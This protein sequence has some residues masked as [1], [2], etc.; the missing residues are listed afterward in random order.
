MR[1]AIRYEPLERR[2]L[3]AADVHFAIDAAQNVHPIS[4]F[5]YGVNESLAGPYSNL[6][7]TRAGGNRWTAYNWENNGSNAGSDYYFQ[8]DSYL[9]GGN[10]PGGAVMPTLNDASSHNAGAIVTIPMAG[11]VSADKNG[12][13][14]VRYNN[15]T[16]NGSGWT[17]G[18]PNPN[19]LAERFRQLIARKGSA[20][21]LTPNTLDPNVYT[22]E[23]VNWIKTNYAYGFT[24]PNR[25]IWFDLDNEPDLWSSTHA[26]VHP[27][28][29]T[30]AEMVQKTTEYA[31]AIKDVI[32]NALILG[33]VNY[34]WQ[35]YVRLQDAPDANN[36]DFQQFF[37]QQMQQ[38]SQTAGRRLLDVMD[39]HW[40]PEAQGT[41]GVRITNQD[42][43]AATVAAR[44]QAPRSLWDPAYT[45]TS[46]ITQWSTQGPIN[47]I[48]RL[49]T[50]INTYYPGTKLAISEYNY[51]GGN[52]ISGG[53]AQAD[54]LGILGREGVFGA[55]LWRLAGDESFIGGA[56]RMFRNYDGANSTFGD[57]SVR[58]TT[59]N[60]ANTSIYASYDQANRSVLTLV[61]INKTA[62]PLTAG[63]DLSHVAAGSQASVWRL[64]SANS[65]PQSAGTISIGNPASFEYAMPAYSV[66]TIRINLATPVAR[67][68]TGGGDN[69][70]WS[71]PANWSGNAVPTASD[72][73]IISV[74]SA[75]ITTTLDSG[76]I[77]VR[78][79]TSDENLT[80]T[81]AGSSLTVSANTTI[82]GNL[83]IENG[84]RFT[85]APN[86]AALAKLTS[87]LSVAGAGSKLDLNNN[88]LLIDYTT[89]SPLAAV[90]SLINAARAG[91]SWAGDGLTSTTA[92]DNPS[93]NTTL[94][95]IESGDFIPL[96][97]NTFRGAEIDSTA[98]LVKY[99]YYGDAN[100]DG[101]VT[102][103]D[104]VRI[105]TGFNQHRTGWLNGDFN[106]DG[107]VNFDDYVLIDI[108][109]NTQG[110]TLGR[111]S[112]RGVGQRAGGRARSA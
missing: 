3:F 41:N 67:V 92:K 68:W 66:S 36:R 57:T 45:E 13:G 34:G 101:R 32:P 20:F 10:T 27:N 104:Y 14:D 21:A 23:F 86:S 98:V 102:F 77:A 106:L 7:L 11:Y 82:N 84:G 100:F 9:G 60:V 56:F 90:Q 48:N 76:S 97:G 40:Y 105:D 1:S 111:L 91:G 53:I 33:P 85:V 30:Y 89:A 28:K 103:D 54:V 109:F 19:Y 25:P 110:G 88:D 2:F 78:S 69:V 12:G 29:A 72:D 74:P 61:A 87:S 96:Y 70:H 26:E 80:I 81:G 47:L 58:A 79:L 16:W 37:L 18:T 43:A 71:D 51:G 15:N 44:L 31:G 24:D 94:G 108:S 107:A 55:N 50:K 112:G 83:S 46:W 62:G 17:N 52:H 49:N 99:T 22:D 35:G 42:N 59:D 64:T 75:T 8:S 5:I 73:V 63:I 93:G 95:A 6:T 39:V 38:A 4:W 65:S